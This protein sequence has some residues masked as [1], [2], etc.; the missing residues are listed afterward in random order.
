V[1]D[2]SFAFLGSGEFD[3]WSEPVE[4]WLLAR[5]RNP[6]GPVL[7]CPTAAAHEGDES[8]DGWA[9][10]GLEHYRGLGIAADVLPLRTRDDAIRD[11]VGARLDDASAIF[12]SGGN[13]AR[14]AQAVVDT[15]FWASLQ[16]ALRDGLPYAGCSAGVACLTEKTFDSDRQD[17]DSVWAPGIGYVKD[18]LFGPHWDI[19]DTW[20][21]GATD[22]IAGSVGRGQT[23]IGL[24]EET[25]MVGD[26]RAWEVM[27]RAKV[28][29]LRDEEWTRYA[30][31]DAF[32]LPLRL[33]DGPA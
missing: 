23:F 2:L 26:G 5:S 29:V 16:T 8:Y 10:K 17:F 6:S 1:S 30:E 13:P 31:G 28:H 32:E 19:V 24:D 11:E 21:P 12:F 22:F 9:N 3:P 18:T 25:A 33:A 7:V 14:L 4:R 20:I 27:G 15:P